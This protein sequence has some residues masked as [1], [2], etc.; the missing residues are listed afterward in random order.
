MTGRQKPLRLERLLFRFNDVIPCSELGRGLCPNNKLQGI[1]IFSIKL[2]LNE[3]LFRCIYR[4]VK[5][6]KGD[7]R[8]WR[9]CMA[10]G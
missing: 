7:R 9:D 5:K 3:Y 10:R 2:N 4:G 1:F 8:D 6:W